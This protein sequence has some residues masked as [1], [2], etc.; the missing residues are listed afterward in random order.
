MRKLLP[1][2]PSWTPFWVMLP[3]LD[4]DFRRLVLWSYRLF[5]RLQMMSWLMSLTAPFATAGV[6]MMLRRRSDAL[7]VEV[8]AL[9]RAVRDRRSRTA[10]GARVVPARPSAVPVGNPWV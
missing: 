9:K 3:A 1:L 4:P 5:I 10:M 7:S 8:A 2:L 6:L